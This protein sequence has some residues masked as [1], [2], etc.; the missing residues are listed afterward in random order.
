MPPSMPLGDSTQGMPGFMAIYRK[1][2]VHRAVVQMRR[3]HAEVFGQVS[4][5]QN[6]AFISV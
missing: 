1:R 5:A 2:L 4:G 6:V 3:R